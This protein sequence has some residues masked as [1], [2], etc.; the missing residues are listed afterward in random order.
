MTEATSEAANPRNAKGLVRFVAG[1]PYVD[2]AERARANK[3]KELR[4]AAGK[5]WDPSGLIIPVERREYL[6]AGSD[7]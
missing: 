2:H 7:Q 6:S 1:K 3:E 5:S 4:E